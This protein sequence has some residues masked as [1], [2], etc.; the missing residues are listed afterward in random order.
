MTT[1]PAIDLMNYLA[2]ATDAGAKAAVMEVSSHA[3]DQQ[4]CAGVKFDA[5]V[6]SNL[7]GDHL[8]YH[9]DMETYL[10]AKKKLF[11]NLDSN[12][13]AIT[14]ADDPAGRKILSDCPARQISFG[15]AGETE[16][17]SDLDI[18]ARVLESSDKGIHFDLLVNPEILSDGQAEQHCEIT[19]PL[20]GLFNVQNCLAASAAAV[21]LGVPLSVIAS[22]L[23]TVDGVPGRMQRVKVDGARVAEEPENDYTVLVDYAHTDHALENALS[24][25]RPL[26][27]GRLVV[28]FG[29][30]GDRD[31]SKRPRMASIAADWADRIMVTSDNPRTEDPQQ[32]ISHIMEG[33]TEQQREKVQVQPDRRKAIREV[34]AQAQK[35]DVILIAGKGHETY[36]IIGKERLDFDDAAEAAH[37]LE[38]LQQNRVTE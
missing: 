28:L 11:D 27:K 38:E 1:P 17:P 8:D 5:G 21:A 24:T 6:F 13:I 31:T 3:L 37:V 20:I 9:R 34:I 29:C 2:E 4:R 18:Y 32:I 10:K 30:G 23:S 25:L 16:K 26:A 36:Q 22:A 33:F 7:S 19:S 15:I 12:A 14:N 35:G